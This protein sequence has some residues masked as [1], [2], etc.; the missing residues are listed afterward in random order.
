M[1]P[2]LATDTKPPARR[3]GREEPDQGSTGPAKARRRVLIVE[4]NLDTVHT[5]ARLVQEMGH[6]A[7]Y[8]IN[9]YAAMGLARRFR[10][11]FILLDLGLP[12]MDGFDVCRRLKKEPGMEHTRFIAITGYAQEEYRQRSRAAGFDLH[13][14]KPLDPRVLEKLLD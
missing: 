6:I 11:D 13:L 2:I 4:D 5:L 9:G 3:N 12:G 14:T 8:A 1:E 10:P 7:D